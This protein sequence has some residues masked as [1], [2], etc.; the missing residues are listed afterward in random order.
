M[1]S[2]DSTEGASKLN[3]LQV[4]IALLSSPQEE[5]GARRGVVWGESC[6]QKK[7]DDSP[8][9]TSALGQTHL[10]GSIVASFS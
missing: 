2:N 10:Y 9:S 6:S 4:Q 1:P 8:A 7:F 5:G 3:R